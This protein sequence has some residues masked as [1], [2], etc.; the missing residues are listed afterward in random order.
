M[1]W[2]KKKTH[3]AQINFDDFV[4]LSAWVSAQQHVGVFAGKRGDLFA[5]RSTQVLAHAAIEW[6][7][8]GGGADLGAHVANGAHARARDGVDARTKV[9]DNGASA[10]FDR[11][12]AGHFKDNILWRRPAT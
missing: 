6:K 5:A 1:W 2:Y 10:A 3:F 4:I 11:Q 12:N 9:L 7:D 8:R